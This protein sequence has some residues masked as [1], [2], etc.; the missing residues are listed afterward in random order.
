[1]IGSL[2]SVVAGS[3]RGT[4]SVVCCVTRVGW[5]KPCACIQTHATAQV[6]V[7]VRLCTPSPHEHTR[8][9]QVGSRAAARV[10][11]VRHAQSARARVCMHVWSACV[12]A[13]TQR[14]HVLSA[15][16][17]SQVLPCV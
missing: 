16:V 5:A 17:P 15:R 11:L 2:S 12:C 3:R 6:D 1:M 14:A 13:R 8:A 4:V 9:Q 10:T 7:A